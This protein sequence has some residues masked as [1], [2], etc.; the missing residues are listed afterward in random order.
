MT[1]NNRAGRCR[2]ATRHVFDEVHRLLRSK[3]F[4]RVPTILLGKGKK[5]VG[6]PYSVD[7]NHA[8]YLIGQSDWK[9]KRW[10]RAMSSFKKALRHDRKDWMTLWAIGDCYDELKYPKM[11]LRYYTNALKRAPKEPA[12]RY[13]AANALIDLARFEEA[14]TQL[15]RIATK[16]REL[17]HKV[18]KNLEL[19]TTAIE[20][21]QQP[22]RAQLV[23]R[24]MPFHRKH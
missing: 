15:R 1:K 14:I 21:E 24:S 12:L 19:A 16:D 22:C 17:R 10:D 23:R 5:R 3:D 7:L 4:R 8:W 11:A 6:S 2:G 18:R 13:N 20:E 9:A